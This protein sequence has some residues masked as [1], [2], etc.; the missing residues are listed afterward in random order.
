MLLFLGGADGGVAFAVDDFDGGEFA[1]FF[2]L[3]LDDFV[4][5]FEGIDVGGDWAF[6]DFYGG[7][8]GVGFV[9][10]FGGFAFFV[11]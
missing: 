6:P 10:D 2:D 1:V 11:F 5:D 4:A 8:E 3:L 9:F 7:V